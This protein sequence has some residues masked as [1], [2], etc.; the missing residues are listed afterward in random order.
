MLYTPCK[1]AVKRK[2][3]YSEDGA[4][5]K[6]QFLINTFFPR[7]NLTVDSLTEVNN[8]TNTSDGEP[9]LMCANGFYPSE[10]G[11]CLPDCAEFH[12]YPTAAGEAAAST[13][14]LIAAVVGIASGIVVILLSCVQYKQV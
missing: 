4:M 7:S 5:A 1:H 6:V 10:T 13:L 11:V 9:G 14:I 12:L 8:R 2:I 3:V